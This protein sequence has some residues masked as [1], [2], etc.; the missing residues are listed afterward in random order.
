MI[1]GRTWKPTKDTWPACSRRLLGRHLRSITGDSWYGG[2]IE[3]H[4][5]IGLS[6]TGTAVNTRAEQRKRSA[7]SPTVSIYLRLV[8][9]YRMTAVTCEA[10]TYMK[11]IHRKYCLASAILHTRRESR[12]HNPRSYGEILCMVGTPEGL[13]SNALFSGESLISF[14]KHT[15]KGR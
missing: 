3:K 4:C 9:I 11:R 2:S 15:W 1:L 14:F 5:L 8:G 13:Q 12:F 10:S 7:R 6:S